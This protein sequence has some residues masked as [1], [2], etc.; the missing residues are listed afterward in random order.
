[1]DNSRPLLSPWVGGVGPLTQSKFC[2]FRAT[3]TLD[4][5]A[6]LSAQVQVYILWTILRLILSVYNSFDCPKRKKSIHG[7]S[8]EPDENYKE[9]YHLQWYQS[10][11]G[12][13]RNHL[14]IPFQQILFLGWPKLLQG[15]TERCRASFNP[16][17]EQALLHASS[18]P[19]AIPKSRGKIRSKGR[20]K[21][22]CKLLTHS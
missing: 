19:G 22:S 18:H 6:K 12:P 1:M 17:T 16:T 4:Y 3:G 20:D 5:T 21:N 7:G 10:G 9:L 15:Y 8:K 11:P 13:H 2:Q 14:Q